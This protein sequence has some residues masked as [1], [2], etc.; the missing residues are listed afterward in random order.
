MKSI[1]FIHAVNIKI[2]QRLNFSFCFC[3]KVNREYSFFCY[4]RNDFNIYKAII[5]YGDITYVFFRFLNY[6]N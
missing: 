1:S 3:H 2:K 4:D 5:S 6:G